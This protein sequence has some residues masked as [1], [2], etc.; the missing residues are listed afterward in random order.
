MTNISGVHKYGMERRIVRDRE[1]FTTGWKL[2]VAH[3]FF[4]YGGTEDYLLG[5]RGDK[6]C[7]H[8]PPPILAPPALITS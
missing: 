6:L 1:A 5:P 2:E 3:K 4:F 8:T 7:T